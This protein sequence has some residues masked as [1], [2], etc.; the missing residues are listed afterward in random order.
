M[1]FPANIFYF[2]KPKANKKLPKVFNNYILNRNVQLYSF[3]EVQDY[4]NSLLQN[5]EVIQ[6]KDFG[7]GSKKFN[8]NSRVIKDI[9]SISA[10]KP[11]FGGMFQ[12]LVEHHNVK[13][14][15]ELGTSVGVGAM[16]FAKTN[17]S[18]SV[19]TIEACPE[20]YS[21]TKKQFAKLDVKNVEF[22]NSTFDEVFEKNLLQKKRYELIYIDGNHNS[23]SVIKYFDYIVENLTDK[24]FI[25][26][27]DD[28]NWSI[29]MHN[30]WK[31]IC[32]TQKNSL[33]IDLYR[34]GIVFAGYDY[35]K[36][37]FPLNFVNKAGL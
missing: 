26:I 21:F 30:A 2:L 24:K 9:A 13:S 33:R 10:T 16:Y 36:G 19:T 4:Q 11:S 25:I 29:D 35:P 28:I 23:K 14:I 37:V 12:K 6:M 20:T 31:R 32:R 27:V 7:T 1:K 8:D 3:G 15:L 22:V 5:E 34:M 18:T 17:E